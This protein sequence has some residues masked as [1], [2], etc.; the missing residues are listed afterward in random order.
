MI[1]YFV[2]KSTY[3]IGIIKEFENSQLIHIFYKIE[4]SYLGSSKFKIVKIYG[5]NMQVNIIGRAYM[6]IGKS[7]LFT[8]KFLIK[9]HFL[10]LF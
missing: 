2:R 8:T 9:L 7:D 3:C 10:A 1:V 6:C 5:D 4:M